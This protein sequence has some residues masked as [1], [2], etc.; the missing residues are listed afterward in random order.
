MAFRA[1]RPLS[2]SYARATEWLERSN[3]L[4]QFLSKYVTDLF[5]QGL[6]WKPIPVNKSGLREMLLFNNAYIS[7][8]VIPTTDNSHPFDL[9]P[10]GNCGP[11]TT[12]CRG[13]AGDV[14]GLSYSTACPCKYGVKIDIFFYGK[15]QQLLLSHIYSH[16]LHYN[17]ISSDDVNIGI[18]LHFP[19]EI[20][21]KN[22][23]ELL[24]GMIGERC[25]GSGITQA[26]QFIED[27][28]RATL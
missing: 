28:P 23:E 15:C 16:L 21:S 12:R 7:M 26:I 1:N 13:Q 3:Q 18:N 11:Q 9:I 20:D 22:V 17:S 27:I 24:K 25:R 10:V 6:S 8:D 14:V 19:Q 2:L 4:L 5:P